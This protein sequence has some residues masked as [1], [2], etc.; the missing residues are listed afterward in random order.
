[1]AFI[2]IDGSDLERT[3]AHVDSYRR[4]AREEYGREIQIW[5]GAPV[6]QRETMKEAQDYAHY[7][8]V[9]KG[10]DEAVD[11]LL[12]IQNIEMHK[13]VPEKAD[14]LPLCREARLGRL[15]ADRQTRRI[16][17]STGY[18]NYR[19]S[20]SMACCCAGSTIGTGCD[21]GRRM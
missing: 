4:I 12:R 21:A 11:N 5:S 2:H 13:L 8:A 9:E 3:R 17:S 15:S 1:M 10:D 16:T 19:R 20:A 6:V 18:K 14:K 7:Y